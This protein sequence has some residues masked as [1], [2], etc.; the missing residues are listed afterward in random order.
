MPTE[1][2]NANPPN[3]KRRWFQFNLRTLLIVV[4]LLA[5][6]CGYV[7]R[8]AKIVTERKALLVRFSGLRCQLCYA[9]FAPGLTPDDYKPST[10]WLRRFFGA[11]ARG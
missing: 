3:R 9:G 4:T 8:Q 11:P 6:V 7:A 2:S 1:P 5:A 10:T